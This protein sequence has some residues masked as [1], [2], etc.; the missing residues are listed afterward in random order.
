MG[1]D[2]V[3]CS[4]AFF[5]IKSAENKLSFV[6]KL[7]FH[8]L[9]QR[10]R[11]KYW[12]PISADLTKLIDFRNALAHFETAVI[13]EQGIKKLKPPLSKYMWIMTSHHLDFHA[14]RSGSM[15]G[16]T[17]E[18][19]EENACKMKISTFML[20]YFSVDHVQLTEPLL[21]SLPPKLQQWWDSF[22]RMPRP[23]GFEPP[24]KSFRVKY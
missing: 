13:N 9:P 7:V 5:Q 24:H 15:K 22:R 21:K 3:A 8:K 12:L 14:N 18:N 17:I 4:L 20:M 23:Q 10:V 16:L 11:T 1:T 6:D 19:I 2:P